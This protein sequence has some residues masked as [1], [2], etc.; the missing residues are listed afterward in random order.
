MQ[1]REI[2]V[3]ADEPPYILLWSADEAVAVIGGLGIGIVLDCVPAALAAGL[4]VARLYR[5]FRDQR[6]R[7]YLYHLAYRAGLGFTRSRTMANPFAR[8][9]LP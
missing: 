6:P 3:R 5:R 7:G 8:W 4:A 9:W 1:P 2:P